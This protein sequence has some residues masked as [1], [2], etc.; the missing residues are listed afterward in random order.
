MSGS[1]EET[2]GPCRPPESSSRPFIGPQV[3]VAFKE[4]IPHGSFTSQEGVKE[5]VV[6]GMANESKERM[7]SKSEE[8]GSTIIGP[9]PSSCDNQQEIINIFER[10][11]ELMREKLLNQVSMK[12]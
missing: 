7:T 1:E 12:K 10:R 6:E 8:D 4:L 9:V 2:F 5:S 3:P 11:A